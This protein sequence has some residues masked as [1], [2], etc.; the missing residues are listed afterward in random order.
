M[1]IV[2]ILAAVELNSALK[3][4][5]TPEKIENTAGFDLYRL[6][7]EE[8]TLYLLQCGIG[9]IAAA[10]GTQYLISVCGAELV[11]NFGV[12]GGLTP[13]M[14]VCR[15][16]VVEKVVHYKFDLSEG[17]YGLAE[18]QC[19]GQES[20]WIAT[21]SALVEAA[22]TAEPSLMPVTC[23]SGDK[24]IGTTEEKAFLHQ[25]WNADICEMEAAA[26]VLTC[27]RNKIPCLSLKAVSDGLLDG[28]ESFW[29]AVERAG[30]AC[31]Q[32]ADRVIRMYFRH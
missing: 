23:A 10:A 31:I 16:C 9:E 7:R 18:G 12:V 21:D 24:F 11:V 26:I 4:Y 27:Q 3:H 5:G 32:T 20:P 30:D 29:D 25:K 15:L 17:G 28:A 8:Y 14:A 6:E 22:R 2:G 19:E 1:H 13:E